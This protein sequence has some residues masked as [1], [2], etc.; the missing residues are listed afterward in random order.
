MSSS[1]IV[2]VVFVGSLCSNRLVYIYISMWTAFQESGYIFSNVYSS[3]VK[4]ESLQL[5]FLGVKLA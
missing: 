1:L 3:C 2:V 4:L 5:S